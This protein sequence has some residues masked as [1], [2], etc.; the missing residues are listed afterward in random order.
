MTIV[1]GFDP[2]A[3][4]RAV[5]HLAAMLARS[6]DADLVVCAVIPEAWPPG[7]GRV[8]AEY[9]AEVEA[10]AAGA[11]QQA[12]SRIGEDVPISLVVEHA[13]SAAAG[14]LEVAERHEATIVVAGSALHGPMGQVTLGSVTSRLLHSSHVAVALAPRGFRAR[15]DARVRRVTAAYGGTGTELVG[16]AGRVTARVGASLR[17]ASFAVH[18]RA[19]VTAGVGQSA[20]EAIVS[21]WLVETRASLPRDCEFVVGRGETFEEAIEDVEWEDGDVLVVGSSE[22]GPVARVFLGSH[23]TK[24]VRVSP[25]PVVVVPREVAERSA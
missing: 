4:G 19:P 12:R 15:P 14:L 8:D 24:I 23:A 7:P 21:E 16:A 10:I 20:D 17:V 22:L 1:A 11:L 13:R 3:H 5:L 2:D 6:A 18:R 25:V 9:R